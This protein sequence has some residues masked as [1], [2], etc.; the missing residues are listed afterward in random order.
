MRASASFI[1]GKEQ[2]EKM[3]KYDYNESVGTQ[4]VRL[5]TKGD[6]MANK[7]VKVWLCWAILYARPR[8]AKNPQSVSPSKTVFRL[9]DRCFYA[10]M[11]IRRSAACSQ[12]YGLA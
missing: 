9:H 6:T 4:H 5:V 3:G 2:I 1:F 8:L 7:K 11:V 12:L 10:E